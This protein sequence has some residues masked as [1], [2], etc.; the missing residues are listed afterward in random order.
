MTEQPA[1]ADR[2]RTDALRQRDDGPGA[3]VRSRPLGHRRPLRAEPTVFRPAAFNPT[4]SCLI[5]KL[6]GGGD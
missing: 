2:C 3:S 1:L 5:S 4:V 6:A